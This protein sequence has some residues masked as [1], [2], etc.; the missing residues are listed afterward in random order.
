MREKW[1]NILLSSS[2]GLFLALYVWAA[3][4]YGLTRESTISQFIWV[5]GGTFLLWLV[6]HVARGQMPGTGIFP[7]LTS[8]AV[9][10]YGW[11]VT[12]MAMV[13]AAVTEGRLQGWDDGFRAWLLLNC[14]AYDV[15]LSLPAM[16]RTTALLGAML[17]AVE[18]WRDPKWSRRLLLTMVFSSFGMVIFFF[19]QR[20][21]GGIFILKAENGT[22]DLSFATYRYW[23][24]AGAYLNLFW[25]VTAAIALFTVV[26]QRPAWPLWMI[27]FTAVFVAS[28]LNVSKAGNVLAA[29]GIV[30]LMVMMAPLC[31]SEM[32]RFRRKLSS[33]YVL[34]A[35]IPILV[36]AIS[37]PFALPW[38]R[39]NYLAATVHQPNDGRTHAYLSFLKIL[40]DSGWIGFG[41]GSFKR[42]YFR[43]VED[44]PKLRTQ[45]YWAA[46]QD[47]IQTL[48]EWGYAGTILWAAVMI[49]PGI[50]LLRG[51]R[52]DSEKPSQEFEGYRIGFLDHVKAFFNN[53]PSSREPWIAIPAFVSVVLTSLHSMV[54]FP[55]QIA[56][57][58]LYFLVF[59]ALGWS[60]IGSTGRREEPP[61]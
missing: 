4:A 29:I 5:M 25:P 30:L 19:L 45:S 15:G 26:R 51:S 7:W 12:I 13:D 9:L 31:R 54:D 55:M 3:V 47:L 1:G 49:P 53:V 27:P 52:R 20:I 44:D 18:I 33:T 32:K 24:N 6:A 21:V 42:Y 22:T 57:L 23:G 60:Y 35:I 34:A 39:W 37:L 14:S 58:Q 11:F 41:P 59:L 61:P 17:I 36:V 50:S 43:Y 48:V 2:Y 38:K 56:S 8:S 16:L 40:P 28:F 10:V 46:H